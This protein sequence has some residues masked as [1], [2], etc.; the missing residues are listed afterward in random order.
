MLSGR[1]TAAELGRRD[2]FQLFE[3]LAEMLAVTKTGLQSDIRYAVG[4]GA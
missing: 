3:D 1:D 4:S 2:P